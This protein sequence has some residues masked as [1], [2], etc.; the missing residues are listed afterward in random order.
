MA[1]ISKRLKGGNNAVDSQT[2]YLVGSC[3]DAANVVYLIKIRRLS[4]CP[5]SWRLLGSS[6]KRY[7][8]TEL[9][10]PDEWPEFPQ[11]R[12]SITSG[13]RRETIWEPKRP[14]LSSARFKLSALLRRMAGSSLLRRRAC[15]R[16]VDSTG[17]K[18]F[19]FNKAT[20]RSL[21]RALQRKRIR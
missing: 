14:F 4:T 10:I 21:R 18:C 19:R 13:L 5:L 3:S 6:S 12:E 1:Q 11:N 9:S 16:P 20:Y 15:Y 17:E 8:K 2:T 7:W